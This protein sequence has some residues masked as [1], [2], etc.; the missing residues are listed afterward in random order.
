MSKIIKKKNNG[1]SFNYKFHFFLSKSSLASMYSDQNLPFTDSRFVR[2]SMV[3]EKIKERLDRYKSTMFFLDEFIIFII[4]RFNLCQ[5]TV[6]FPTLK[7]SNYRYY[8]EF[9]L[10]L[11][12]ENFR[13]P[14]DIINFFSTNSESDLQIVEF[15]ENIPFLFYFCCFESESKLLGRFSYSF[16]IH[17]FLKQNTNVSLSGCR[18]HLEDDQ[19]PNSLDLNKIH[20]VL[21]DSNNNIIFDKVF[22]DSSGLV[23]IK[24]EENIH[25]DLNMNPISNLNFSKTKTD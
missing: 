23:I 20:L 15:N 13:T 11:T 12:V 22:Q 1:P 10:F 8:G 21:K 5:V 6:S 16:S 24:Q 2:N 4:N 17:K 19:S 18:V 25:H 3:R 7:N 9:V 14:D